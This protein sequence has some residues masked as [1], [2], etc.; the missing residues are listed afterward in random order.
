MRILLIEDEADLAHW[1]SRSLARHAGFVVDWADN[2][3]LAERRLAL[4]EFD[5][6]ILDL[7]LPGMDGH[8]LLTKMR[9]RDD[10]TPVLVL[11]ARDSL[12]ERVGT[13]HEGADDFLP[14]PFV[15]EELE[16]RLTALIRRSRGR[17]H[18]RLSL[19]NLVLDTSAQRFTV[20]G[21]NLQ[22]SPKEY[23]VLR[24]LIQRSGE[25]IN[26]QQILDRI[27]GEDSDVNLEAIEVL[28][29]RLRKK[30]TDTGVQIVTMRGMGYSLEAAVE[31]S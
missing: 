19:G 5:A 18:P 15:L 25:P 2:G 11:T 21:Q 31:N 17:D 22:L 3:L 23:A 16:A 10:R 9:A 8:T 27:Q 28:V 20:S 26:K 24:V 4:E 14:K 12:A 29:H 7:G 13:L 30:L 6:V 1:L